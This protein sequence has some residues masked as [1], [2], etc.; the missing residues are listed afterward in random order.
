MSKL[1]E[2]L[3]EAHRLNLFAP[4]IE[5]GAAAARVVD[6][7]LG[8]EWYS[9]LE[10]VVARRGAAELVD[11]SCAI[12]RGTAR[13]RL[14]EKQGFGF[15]RCTCGHIYVSPQISSSLSYQLAQE[16]DAVDHR[17]RLMQV[18]KLFAAPVCHLLRSRAP[19]PRLL[20]IGFGQGWILRLARSYGFDPY[21][22]ET[23]RT[24]VDALRPF[25]DRHLHLA[26][27]GRSDIPWDG[28]D[29][30]IVSHVLEHLPDPASLLGEIFRVMNPDAVLY[31]AVPDMDSLQFHVF[32]KRWEVVSPL[33][34]LQYF[35]DPTLRQLLHDACLWMWS[36]SSTRQSS[37]NLPRMDAH[38][39]RAR[40]YGRR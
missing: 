22:I 1:G 39:P 11:V 17:S 9:S 40:W 30:V 25:F 18:Q 14:F 6:S 29:A 37:P 21:G 7:A 33:A 34:H 27:P 19:G 20:D 13:R 4:G 28:F 8:L 24:H 36:G 15:Y 16:L 3:E 10:E 12:C 35:T 31:V 23:S 5:S 32:G 38:G 26:A 2:S